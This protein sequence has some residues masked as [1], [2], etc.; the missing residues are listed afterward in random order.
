VLE[1]AAANAPLGSTVTIYL[2]GPDQLAD[3]EV[4]LG[5]VCDLGRGPG[6][7]AVDATDSSI[8]F[9]P[10]RIRSIGNEQAIISAGV[11]PGERI[12]ALGGQLLRQ[13]EHVHAVSYEASAR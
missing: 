7:W 11:R 9:R 12:V 13:N 3:T 5:A 2:P 6:V 8:L 1:G 10:V 4:P